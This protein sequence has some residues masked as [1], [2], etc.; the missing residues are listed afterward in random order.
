MHEVYSKASTPVF[1]RRF[2][3]FSHLH[4]TRPSI[5][6]FSNT[7]LKLTKSKY[8]ISVRGP[9]IWNDFVED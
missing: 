3:K 8:R 4:S 6:D 7:K 2:Q 1:I 9:I 5:L